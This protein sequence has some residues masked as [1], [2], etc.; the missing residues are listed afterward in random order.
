MCTI[1]GE[2]GHTKV[3][4]SNVPRGL[5]TRVLRQDAHA[6]LDDA[7]G[8]RIHDGDAVVIAH[9]S[10]AC[11]DPLGLLDGRSSADFNVG[12]ELADWLLARCMRSVQ[13][14]LNKNAVLKS[15]KRRMERD[16]PG[17]VTLKVIEDAILTAKCS[18]SSLCN[19]LSSQF[20]V[21]VL[22]R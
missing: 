6:V 9:P 20:G 1:E 18:L 19:F 12:G 2:G 7:L 13:L 16:V 5:H 22:F 17:V 3:L 10:V 15:H 11:N 8:C 4:N 21:I 14:H